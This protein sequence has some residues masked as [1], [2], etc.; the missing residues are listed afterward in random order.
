MLAWKYLRWAL[1]SASWLWL[2]SVLLLPGLA[3]AASSSGPVHAVVDANTLPPVPVTGDEVST[4]DAACILP[5]SE[6]PPGP[7]AAWRHVALPHVWG[8]THPGYQGTMWYRFRVTMAR[9]PGSL[10]AIYLPRAVMNAQVWVNGVPMA[11]TGSMS[12]PVTRNWYVPLLVQVPTGVWRDGDNV[13]HIKV[14]SGFM[15]RDGLAPVQIGPLTLLEAPY[16]T[17]LFLQVDGAY[18]ANTAVLALGVFMMIAWLRDR[19]QVAIGFQGASAVLWGAGNAAYLAAHPFFGDA[20]WAPLS[21]TAMVWSALAMALFFRRFVGRRSRLVERGI[22][23]LML[24]TPVWAWLSVSAHLTAFGY[25]VA[26]L[27]FMVCMVQAIH[28]VIKSD[29][30]DGVWLLG[31]CALLVPAAAHDVAF[32]VNLLPF[33]A[34][35]TLPFVSPIMMSCIFYVLAGDYARSRRA[36]NRLNGNLAET[37]AQREAALRESFARLAELE[38]AQAV[39]AERSRI[40]RDMHDGVG[41]HL[42]SALRQLQSP[43]ENKVDLGLVTQTL[44]DSLDQLKL[45]I[46]ALSLQP[47][48]VVGL[49]ASLRF[50]IT[51]RLKAVG[52]E[53]VWDVADLPPWPQG[54]APALRQLQYILFEGLSNVLQHSGATRLTLSA[55]AKVD[56]L[57]VSL[58]DNGRGWSGEGEGQGLQAMR[59]RAGVIGARIAFLAR[60]EGGAELRVSLPLK[61]GSGPDSGPDPELDLSSAA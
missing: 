24:V 17:R 44:R 1:R 55:H 14:V 20:V 34:I 36:L 28:G 21:V 61:A 6:M 13:I 41:A 45:S 23:G 40:L 33:D 50:R 22:L 26:Y 46:D 16:K 42:T 27:I 52:L 43:Q 15:S 7:Q 30:R 19:D 9:A 57:E 8:H 29:R 12:E 32:Q 18:F 31:G 48:D 58:I 11:Y 37:L 3:G 60:P 56:C 4:L 59:A 38:R 35:Y 51:P 10:W 39:S 25:G 5:G 47:G 2:A 49:L 53:L 54:Q